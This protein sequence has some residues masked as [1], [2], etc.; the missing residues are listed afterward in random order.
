L[1]KAINTS[2]LKFYSFMRNLLRNSITLILFI[3]CL[4][5]AYSQPKNAAD[6]SKYYLLR[7]LQIFDGEEM[8]K[9]AWVLVK[10]NVIKEV[11]APGSFNFPSNCVIID[12]PNQTLLPGL[13]DGY[14]HL[15]LHPY[16]EVSWGDQILKE[17]RSERVLRAAANAKTTLLAGFTTIRDMGTVGADF[18]DVGLRRSIE[19]GIII[20]PR[21]LIATRGI[22]ASGVYT[23]K[24]LA[25]ESDVPKGAI[26][27][28]G[29]D[30]L[31]KEVRTE[32]GAGA[33]VIYVYSETIP[34]KTV[35][36]MATFTKDELKV[37]VDLAKTAQIQVAAET[38]T[39]DGI[40]RAVNAGITN[41]MHADDCTL[42]LLKLMKLR[43][44]SIY[45]ALANNELLTI[46]SGWKRGIDPD[47]DNIQN[48]K[49]TIDDAIRLGVNICF[50]S[51]AGGIVAH[52]KN[53]L[54]MELM[55]D[56]GMNNIDVLRSAT[57]GN[58]DLFNL[59]SKVGRI[60]QGLLA[61]LIAVD[62]DPTKDVS[63]IEQLRFVMKDGVVYKDN[64]DQ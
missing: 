64:L 22:I 16:S 17:S 29:K 13:I 49:Q 7:P 28:D 50:G 6:T 14:T 37:I 30:A 1:I 18:E 60:K 12:M 42:D 19:K 58:A 26:E 24:D 31:L 4:H 9:N 57:S 52:G 8:V 45:P 44:T 35:P 5:Q 62:G 43:G 21:L 33:D 36:A 15:F 55:A 32:A 48:K 46:S 23:S 51:D 41:I 39:Q 56:Y 27:A 47:P 3:F 11:G 61:D 10:N 2:R 34:T 38:N 54:E 53:Y 25:N 63:K 20:G 40:K 59:S